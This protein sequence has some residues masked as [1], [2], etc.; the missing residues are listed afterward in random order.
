[1]SWALI[2]QYSW[3]D[4]ENE[5][6]MASQAFNVENMTCAT[7]PIAVK[8]AMSRVGG[9]QNVKVDFDT[10]IATVV[11]DSALTDSAI[12]ANASSS[13]GFPATVVNEKDEQTN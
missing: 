5:S 10:K 3:A 7:C 11:Y 1:M 4:Q 12:I 6:H 9:V 13:V 8:T 2:A